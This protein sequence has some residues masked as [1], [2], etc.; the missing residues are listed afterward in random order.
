M[1][2]KASLSG[3]TLVELA[4]VMVVIGLLIGGILKGQELIYLAKLNKTAT[5]MSSFNAAF[6]TFKDKYN[7]IPGDIATATSRVPNCNASNSCRNGNGDQNI[8][9]PL[10]IWQNNG[11]TITTENAQFWKHLALA[12]LITGVNPSADT[13]DVSEGLPKTAMGGYFDVVTGIAVANGDPAALIGSHVRL[14][15]CATCTNT[16]TPIGEQV[17]TPYEASYIDRKID[18]GSPMTGWVRSS[19]AGRGTAGGCEGTIYDPS[20]SEEKRC[21]L[22]IKLQ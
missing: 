19:S 22:Y 8:G 5:Q 20:L 2:K 21:V 13:T 18:D 10:P 6:H 3:F 17:A 1:E 9:I 12:D 14:L 16:E 11:G 7:A 15:T 4:I